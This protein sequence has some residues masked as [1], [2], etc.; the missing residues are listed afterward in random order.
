MRHLALTRLARWTR[1]RLARDQ[2]GSLINATGK[3]IVWTSGATES[4]NLAIKGIAKYYELAQQPI[5]A[6]DIT[7]VDRTQKRIRMLARL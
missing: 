1:S 5:E 4:N 7:G 6:G 2:V 3:E